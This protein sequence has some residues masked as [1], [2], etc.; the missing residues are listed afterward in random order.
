MPIATAMTIPIE[1]TASIAV[2]GEGTKSESVFNQARSDICGRMECM[3]RIHSHLAER[4]K[5][6]ES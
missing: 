4:G 5:S 2:S 1:I 3:T 6:R